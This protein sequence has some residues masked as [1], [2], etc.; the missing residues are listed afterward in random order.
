MVTATP[1]LCIVDYYFH[2]CQ[3]Q[4]SW[5]RKVFGQGFPPQHPQ[6]TS[7]EMHLGEHPPPAPIN[8][9]LPVMP[10]TPSWQEVLLRSLII[11]HSLLLLFFLSFFAQG[12]LQTSLGTA[13]AS[14]TSVLIVL[15]SS[16]LEI[17]PSPS[18]S[19]LP[20]LQKDT[21][22]S[23][24]LVS[25]CRLDPSHFIA[26]YLTGWYTSLRRGQRGGHHFVVFSNARK[27]G[28]ESSLRFDRN[29]LRFFF[30]VC[31]IFVYFFVE[32]F[33]ANPLGF[34]QTPV[35]Q[36]ARHNWKAAA[37]CVY[38]IQPPHPLVKVTP[39]QVTGIAPRLDGFLGCFLFL[40]LKFRMNLICDRYPEGI[41]EP[42]SRHWGW[43]G[44]RK[45]HQ[46]SSSLIR[47]IWTSALKLHIS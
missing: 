17:R 43:L 31:C 34:Q 1:L 3:R 8:S 18:P 11:R 19:P 12:F 25:V 38:S 24:R 32:R 22:I 29:P 42:V 26:P 9:T 14:I 4:N 37:A 20:R 40:C 5:V 27:N 2:A 28:E 39:R 41:V 45:Q 13:S 7:L 30:F 23:P 47:V 46:H 16:L 21:E 35:T 6:S 15:K 10:N 44:W 36:F 33:E